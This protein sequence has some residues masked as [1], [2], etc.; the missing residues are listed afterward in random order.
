MPAFGFPWSASTKCEGKHDLANEK[1]AGRQ[2]AFL[3]GSLNLPRFDAGCDRAVVRLP[4]R[5]T[6]G[7]LFGG[8]LAI[9]KGALRAT[10]RRTRYGGCRLNSN[11]RRTS[12]QTA[13]AVF[14]VG[15]EEL[16]H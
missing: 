11:G 16:R 15:H 8:A 13:T 14:V 3:T 9:F 4:L 7:M 6:S 5:P 1:L 10:S 12:W 2:V